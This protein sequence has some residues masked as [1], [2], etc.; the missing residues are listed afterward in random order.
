MVVVMCED[1]V[2]ESVK[3]S[4]VM[5]MS[6]GGVIGSLLNKDMQMLNLIQPTVL[7]EKYKSQ[8]LL[9]KLRYSHNNFTELELWISLMMPEE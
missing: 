8:P 2:S 4:V 5:V 6:Q 9:C 3:F 7:A 1:Y